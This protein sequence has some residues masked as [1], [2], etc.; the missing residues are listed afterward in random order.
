MRRMRR[1]LFSLLFGSRGNM[2]FD[3]IVIVAVLLPLASM[4][5]DVPR[6]LIMRARLQAAANNAAEAAASQCIRTDV[7]RNTG[8]VVLDTSCA[9]SA[10][11]DVF[12][13][14][15]SPMTAR[16]YSLS[17]DGMHVNQPNHSVDV[18]ASGTTMVFFGTFPGK[19]IH[20]RARSRFRMTKR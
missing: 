7:F 4:T 18:N 5:V 8:R 6:Y 13:E 15:A 12:S 9:W 19:R 3:A 1:V 2:V 17:L 14:T 10:A 11:R 20:V 16:G